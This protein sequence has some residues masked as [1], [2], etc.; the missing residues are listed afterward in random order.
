MN[1]KLRIAGIAGILTGVALA[2]EFIFFMLSGYNPQLSNDPA[3]ALT[4]LRE[5]GMYIRVAVL[6][7]A[8]GVALRTIFVSGLAASLYAKTP[9][10]AVATLYF[11]IL[12]GAGHGLVALS[13]YI[14]IPML[15]SLAAR[16]PAAAANAWGAYT[17]VISGFEG[18]GNFLIGLMLLAAGWAIASHK[19]L[20]AGAGW[21][22]LLGGLATLVRVF[23][24]GTPLAGIA[25]AVFFPSL[26]LAGV[27]DVWAGIALWRYGARE[28]GRP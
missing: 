21:I 28:R 12:G 17:T 22:G 26:V 16:D 5:S 14:G 4:F 8:A 10:E 11:G 3:A 9:T 2:G 13:F 15:V 23:T 20:S 25:F 7:G 1:P 24:T 19:A 6:F 27:F 18:F